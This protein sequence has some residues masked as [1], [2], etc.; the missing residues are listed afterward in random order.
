MEASDWIQYT[1]EKDQVVNVLDSQ[2][3]ETKQIKAKEEEEE[4][5]YAGQEMSPSSRVEAFKEPSVSI[6]SSVL[7]S[8]P[9]ASS[10]QINDRASHSLQPKVETNC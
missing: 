2:K 9:S 1:T 4:E 10:K 5:M 6:I 7:S 8:S 3:D